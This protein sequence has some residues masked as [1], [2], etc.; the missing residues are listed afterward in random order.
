M[1]IYEY[2]CKNCKHHFETIQSFSD[3]PLVEC[4]EC[5]KAAL[6]KL[7]SAPAFHLKGTGWY[8]TDFKNSGKGADKANDKNDDKKSDTG[9]TTDATASDTSK[10]A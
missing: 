1:P 3:E 7:L 9:A 5:H 8:A 2:A 10:A 6:E 4:P